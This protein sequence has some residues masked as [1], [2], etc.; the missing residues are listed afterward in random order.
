MRKGFVMLG[1]LV[2]LVVS[3][4]VVVP[5]IAYFMVRS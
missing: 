4:T 2:Y 1:F 3:F 5:T